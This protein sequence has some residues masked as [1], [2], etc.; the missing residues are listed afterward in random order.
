MGKGG[1][2]SICS[3]LCGI[4]Y[5]L[6]WE[7]CFFLLSHTHT[8]IPTCTGIL[9]SYEHIHC[10]P[11]SY[12][13][14]CRPHPTAQRILNNL[15]CR[16]QAFSWSWAMHSSSHS[17][18]TAMQSTENTSAYHA[19]AQY[20]TH[21]CV[22][23]TCTVFTHAQVP[24]LFTHTRLPCTVQYLP[25]TQKPAMRTGMAVLFH[26]KLCRFEAFLCLDP[27]TLTVYRCSPC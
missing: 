2:C 21:S 3:L 8:A 17:H 22:S 5:P 20:C 19:L 24:D 10:Y 4:A 11:L 1:L 25:C 27:L 13:P 12:N 14:L 7:S 16:G 15:Y 26:E 9:L 6:L 23:C 18:K